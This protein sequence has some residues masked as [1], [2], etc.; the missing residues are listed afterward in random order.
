MTEL[1]AEKPEST[2][3]KRGAPRKYGD[4]VRHVIAEQR[5]LG[6]SPEEIQRELDKQGLPAPDSRHIRRI[7]DEVL[8]RDRSQPWSLAK[9][10][11]TEA[12]SVPSVL[13]ELIIRSEGRR[14]DVTEKEAEWI[15]R[16]RLAA[17]DFDLWAVYMMAHNYMVRTERGETTADLDTFLAFAPWRGEEQRR[18][19][20]EAVQAGHILVAP[21]HLMHLLTRGRPEIYAAA[22]DYAKSVHDRVVEAG[23]DRLKADLL[24]QARER[25]IPTERAEELVQNIPDEASSG[26][27]AHVENALSGQWDE[28]EAALRD[29]QVAAKQG[30]DDLGISRAMQGLML[31]EQASKE[32]EAEDRDGK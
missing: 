23:R 18:P 5:R 13:A 30:L 25:G 9:A 32:P 19:Y 29:P 8:A 22:R 26:V 11:P 28:A 21:M 15:T 2:P 7:I 17:P 6:K 14:S 12:A 1:Q 20:Y 10:A 3:K 24:D 31:S 16:I 27:W 4:D